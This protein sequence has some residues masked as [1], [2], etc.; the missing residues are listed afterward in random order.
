MRARPAIATIALAAL[1]GLAAC[2][3][4]I[5]RSRAQRDAFQRANP[6]PANGATHGACPGYVVDHI[7]PLCAGGPDAPANMQWQTVDDGKAK[8]RTEHT[9]CARR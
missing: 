2:A 3:A 5:E 4:P 6:C 9:Q 8:D 1:C 7:V